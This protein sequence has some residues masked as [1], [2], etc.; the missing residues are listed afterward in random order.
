MRVAGRFFAGRPPAPARGH[1]PLDPFPVASLAG[2]LP[3]HTQKAQDD[4][5]HL[6]GDTIPLTPFKTGSKGASPLWE[7]EG[8][9]LKKQNPYGALPA[10]TVSST[11]LFSVF[12]PGSP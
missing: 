4:L 3:L 8:N 7:L 5:L 9:A 2:V 1:S 6:Q 10:S 12:V 11:P